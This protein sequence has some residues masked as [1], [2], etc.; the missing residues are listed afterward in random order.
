VLTP[1]LVIT[2]DQLNACVE[3]LAATWASVS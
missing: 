2:P 3:A 1:P